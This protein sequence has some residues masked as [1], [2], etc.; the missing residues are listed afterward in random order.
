MRRAILYWWGTVVLL[1]V[2][3]VVI[4]LLFALRHLVRPGNGPAEKWRLPQPGLRLIYASESAVAE[5]LRMG[6]A[7]RSAHA[8]RDADIGISF[9]MVLP[10]PE[11]LKLNPLPPLPVSALAEPVEETPIAK[12]PALYSASAGTLDALSLRTAGELTAAGYAPRI[13]PAPPPNDRGT[14]TFFVRLDETGRPLHVLRLSPSGGETDWLRTLRITLTRTRGTAA[15]FGQ[16]TIVWNTK[17]L[18]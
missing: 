1:S 18:P 3:A 12:L 4:G 16:V 14:A 8:M 6:N 9:D 10:E 17:D 13:R 11:P 2:T 15:A 5:A 7:R